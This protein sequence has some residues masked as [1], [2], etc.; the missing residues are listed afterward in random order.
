[1]VGRNEVTP[2]RGNSS[3]TIQIE[4]GWSVKSKPKPPFICMSIKP[5]VSSR[6]FAGMSCASGGHG[7]SLRGPT[8]AISPSLTSTAVS[9][10]RISGDST[11]SGSM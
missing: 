6:P 7:I 3:P 9:P 5:G 10:G 8:L 11:L 1:M 4:S 2:Y